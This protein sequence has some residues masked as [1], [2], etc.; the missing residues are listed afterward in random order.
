MTLRLIILVCALLGVSACIGGDPYSNGRGYDYGDS[1]Y[2]GTYGHPDWR[3][4]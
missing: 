1:H 3:G 4:E 2:T